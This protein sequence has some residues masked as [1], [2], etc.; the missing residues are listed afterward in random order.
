MSGDDGF[1]VQLA[2]REPVAVGGQE[3]DLLALDLDPHARE[4][5]QRVV[6][7]GGDGHLGDRVGELVAVDGARGRRHDREVRVVLDRHRQER[8]PART[9]GHDDLG[10]VEDDVDRLVGQG[11]GDLREQAAGD[12]DGAGLAHVGGDLRPGGDLVVEAREL[13]RARGVGLEAHTCQDR[14]RRPSGQAARRPRDGVRENVTVDPEP[15]TSPLVELAWPALPSRVVRRSRRAG[16]RRTLREWSDARYG[17]GDD[18]DSRVVRRGAPVASR[19]LAVCGSPTREVSSSS[20]VLC[21]VWIDRSSVQ[22]R[23]RIRL[24]TRAV[25]RSGRRGGRR[26]DGWRC[27]GSAS[28]GRG[29]AVHIVHGV[30]S[31]VVHRCSAQVWRFVPCMSHPEGEGSR[32]EPRIDSTVRVVSCHDARN[33]RL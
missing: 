6:A 24:C 14:D 1:H 33:A 28:T 30:S 5:R 16:V 11:T 12:Q 3:R 7:A 13:D 15:H 10:A 8:E 20:S 29:R 22:V 32:Q 4:Q 23:P 18:N 31:T 25:G 21:T 26:V 2:Q 19:P 17:H 9:A 27:A